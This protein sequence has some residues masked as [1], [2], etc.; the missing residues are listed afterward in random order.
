MEKHTPLTKIKMPVSLPIINPKHKHPEW[1]KEGHPL[2]Q[3]YASLETARAHYR[4]FF[5]QANR[6][7][8]MAIGRDLFTR[9]GHAQECIYNQYDYSHSAQT[10]AANTVSRI[11]ADWT[12]RFKG[13]FEGA[14]I[15]TPKLLVDIEL[16]APLF[17]LPN[18]S[19]TKL[20]DG[21][22]TNDFIC[23]HPATEASFRNYTIGILMAQYGASKNVNEANPG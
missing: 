13:V 16:D 19:L 6:D 18:E 12:A 1:L 2:L 17:M 21:A 22:H 23:G 5:D 15:D 7:C 3:Y 4:M 11:V 10:F 8:Q 14:G 9:L 20:T